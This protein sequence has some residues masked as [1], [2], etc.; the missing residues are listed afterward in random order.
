M[1][2]G[3]GSFLQE[4]FARRIED[5]DRKCSMQQPVQM[6]LNF[7]SHSNRFVFS[8]NED[9]LIRDRVHSDNLILDFQTSPNIR[10]GL[11]A[12]NVSRQN[13]NFLPYPA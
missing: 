7:V 1:V 9:D 3:P 2:F 6:G 5:E 13:I 12:Y 10:I 8:T 11:A 4:Q